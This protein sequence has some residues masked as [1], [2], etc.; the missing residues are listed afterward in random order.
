MH[1][2]DEKYWSKRDN[3]KWW[4][5]RCLEDPRVIVPK[6][7][8]WTGY[9][10]NFARKRALPVLAGLGVLILLPIIACIILAPQ[11]GGLIL[12]VSGAMIALAVA[13]CHKAANPR[14]WTNQTSPNQQPEGIRH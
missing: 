2:L 11:K 14:S 6:Q 4:G 3:W 8:R 5:Y 7:P 1:P 10:L 12:A 13:I 9:T